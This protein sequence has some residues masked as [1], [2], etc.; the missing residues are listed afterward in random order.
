MNK[1]FFTT[2]IFLFLTVSCS[3]TSSVSEVDQVDEVMGPT[4]VALEFVRLRSTYDFIGTKALLSNEDKEYF[5][6]NDLGISEY[7]DYESLTELLKIFEPYINYDVINTDIRENSAQIKINISTPD[8]TGLMGKF[9][10]DSIGSLFSDTNENSDLENKILSAI[11]EDS[12]QLNDLP[13][14]VSEEVINLI[15]ENGEWRVFENLKFKTILSDAK[16]LQI[17]SEYA[18]AMTKIETALEIDPLNKEARN[19]ADS[20]QE[21]IDKERLKL[22]YFSKIEI[23]EFEAKIFN[24]SIGDGTPGVDFALKNNGDRTLSR[25]EVIVYFLDFDG[26]PI[27]EKSYTPV[28]S[29]EY[30]YTDCYILKPNYVWRDANKFYRADMLGPEW[31]GNATIEIKD[32]EFGD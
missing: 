11:K 5:T 15:R 14:N 9:F 29:G 17:E 6:T 21:E 22:E 19:L 7:F 1:I 23:L 4:E 30:C 8:L 31:S 3:D 26:L 10:R 16:K 24:T 20:I 25:V 18:K 2:F 32:I 12:A 28:R 27:A 13:R